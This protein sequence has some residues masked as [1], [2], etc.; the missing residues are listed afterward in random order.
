MNLKEIN[1]VQIFIN[2]K[3]LNKIKESLYN[4]KNKSLDEITTLYKNL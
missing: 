2:L 3:E 1:N 4:L